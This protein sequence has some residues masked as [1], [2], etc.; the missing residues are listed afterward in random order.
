[1]GC[2]K[3]VSFL[4]ESLFVSLSALRWSEALTKV[5]CLERFVE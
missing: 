3:T 1:M 2:L 4:L 5:I